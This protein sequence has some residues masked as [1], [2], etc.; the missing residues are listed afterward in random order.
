[1]ANGEKTIEEIRQVWLGAAPRKEELIRG[2]L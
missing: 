2:K 1:M